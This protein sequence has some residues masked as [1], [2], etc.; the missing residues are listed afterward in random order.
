M[1]I[2]KFSVKQAESNYEC[3]KGSFIEVDKESVTYQN[4]FE[5]SYIYI[6]INSKQDVLYVGE[7]GA[8]LYARIKGNGS[9]AHSKKEWFEEVQIIRYLNFPNNQYIR[10]KWENEITI[11]LK[12]KYQ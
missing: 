6:L 10:R 3:I 7:T 9:G 1:D 8:S 11:V 2:E 5:G 4:R 12:P